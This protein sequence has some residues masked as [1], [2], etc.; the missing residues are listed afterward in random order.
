M[1]TIEGLHLFLAL[2]PVGLGLTV[3]WLEALAGLLD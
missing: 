1:R 3:L 2:P